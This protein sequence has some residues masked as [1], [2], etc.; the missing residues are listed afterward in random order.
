MRLSALRSPLGVGI[1]ALVL[2]AGAVVFGL[3][4][5]HGMPLVPRKEVRVAFADVSGLDVGDDVRIAG[6]RVGY[7][8]KLSLVD[9]QA[10]AT[11]KLDDPN[12]KLYED[13]I[14]ARVTDRSSLGQKFIELNPGSPKTGP[15]RGNGIIPASQTIK[16]EDIGQLFDAFDPKTRSDA[17]TTLTQLGGGMIG[18]GEGLRALDKNA[19]Q[20]LKNTATVSGAIAAEQGT[21]LASMLATADQLSSNLRTRQTDLSRLIDQFSG[22]VKAFN[23]DAGTQVDHALQK[24]PGALNSLNGALSSINTPLSN[25]ASAM[26]TLRAGASSL[27]LAT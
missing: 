27:G 10:V 1:V 18:H 20:I 15:L 24:A 14:A 9:G 22:T 11:L 16:S 2:F 12:T 8:S 21:P 19:A 25:T 6:A 4:A 3:N 13:A 7:V 23:V 26:T 17:S 5:T